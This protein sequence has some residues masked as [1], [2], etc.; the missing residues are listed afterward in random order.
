M[1]NFEK[2]VLTFG[3]VP[4]TSTCLTDNPCCLCPIRDDMSCTT[5]HKENWWHSE[6]KDADE[7]SGMLL[8][9]YR[10]RYKKEVRKMTKIVIDTEAEIT[11]LENMLENLTDDKDKQSVRF[12]INILRGFEDA[13]NEKMYRSSMD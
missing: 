6:Y 10:E 4:N 11:K 5:E 8:C 3:F 9:N 13:E 12:A 1:T 2:F 7:L